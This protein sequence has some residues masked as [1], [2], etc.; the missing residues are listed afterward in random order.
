MYPGAVEKWRGFALFCCLA[1]FM[2]KFIL[3]YAKIKY[4]SIQIYA[5]ESYGL[6][7]V[8]SFIRKVS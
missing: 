1:V 2:L 4:V 8:G 3:K 7:L 5:L 6:S